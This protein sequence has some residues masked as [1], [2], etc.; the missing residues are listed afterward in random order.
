MKCICCGKRIEEKIG[1][2]PV[3]SGCLTPERQEARIMELPDPLRSTMLRIGRS[4][5]IVAGAEDALR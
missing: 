2:V 4:M 5:G 3:C 1:D